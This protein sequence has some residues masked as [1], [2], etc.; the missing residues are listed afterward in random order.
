MTAG[1]GWNGDALAAR[2][3]VRVVVHGAIGSTMDAAACDPEPPPAVHV[4]ERQ[5]AGRGRA[6]RP[7]ASPP[8]NLYAT[9]AWPDPARELPPGVL[10]AIQVAWAEA[11]ELAGGP[12]VRCKW[13]ND[14]VLAGR[15]WAGVMAVREGET[16]LIGLGANLVAL[17]DDPTIAAAALRP[18]WCGWPGR[19]EAGALLLGAATALLEGGGMA[20]RGHLSRWPDHDLWRPGVPL[21]I[22]SAGRRREG[23]Y[24]GTTLEGLLRLETEDGS[25]TFAGG[26]A[27]RI[28]ARSPD[29]LPAPDPDRSRG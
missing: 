8:G 16:L 22:E 18:H 10:A 13:P 2:L 11:I 28:R 1:S 20:V 14:G 9:I 24:A 4:A 3:G 5:L 26:E 12:R 6:G 7:W 21:A 29:P 17:P 27:I 23:L 15:K 25:E 19:H